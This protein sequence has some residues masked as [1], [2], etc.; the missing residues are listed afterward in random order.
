[1]ATINDCIR[2][3]LL[4]C[5][6]LPSWE[7]RLPINELWICQSFWDWFDATDALHDEKTKV[8]SR[9][10]GEHIEQFL[11]DLRCLERPHAGDVRRMIPNRDCIWSLH[12]PGVRIY[13]W[14]IKV[15]AFV[16]VTGALE[17]ETK[18]KVAGQ[19]SV[20]D[21]KRDEVKRFISTNGLSDKVIKGDILA[22]FP[23][24]AKL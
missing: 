8:G 19:K 9:T 3:Q 4:E 10:F 21:K 7:T 20:N 6:E 16:I 12:S 5:H 1:M 11:C 23:P 17:L 24:K 18:Q 14:A 15:R 2:N 13:G 22:V